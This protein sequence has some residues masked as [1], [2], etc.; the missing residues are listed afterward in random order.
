V[1]TPA[2]TAVPADGVYAGRLV[3][4]DHRGASRS[5]HPAAISVGS[6]PTFAG[7]R[8][9]VEA[10]LLDF[11]GDL[12]GEHVGVEFVERLRPMLAFSGVPDLLAAMAEDVARTRAVLGL[13]ADPA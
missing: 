1:E 13:P 6:N 12:Y 3:L 9:T 2:H 8:R 10:Y 7:S 4:R 5:S 11:E